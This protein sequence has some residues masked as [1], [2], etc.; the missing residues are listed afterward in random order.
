MKF[1]CFLSSVFVLPVLTSGAPVGFGRVIPVYVFDDAAQSKRA[2]NCLI[3]DFKHSMDPGPADRTTAGNPIVQ[4]PKAL[5]VGAEDSTG[6]W[7]EGI[8]KSVKPV[9]YLTDTHAEVTVYVQRL[10]NSTG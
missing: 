3:C 4:T 1:V 5:A 9:R 7:L 6:L 10:P 2:T 8:L